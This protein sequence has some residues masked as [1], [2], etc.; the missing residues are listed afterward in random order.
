MTELNNI[1]SSSHHNED[2]ATQIEPRVEI[3]ANIGDKVSLA[4]QQNDFPLLHNLQ[5]ENLTDEPLE[6]LVLEISAD[7]KFLGGR[8]W[9]FDHFNPGE[10]KRVKDLN[11]TLARQYLAS[12]NEAVRASITIKAF[13]G[14][15]KVGSWSQAVKVLAPEDWGGFSHLPDLTAAFCRPNDPAV[16]KV[17]KAAA[18]ALKQAGKGGQISGYQSKDRNQVWKQVSAIYTAICSLRLDY[19]EPPASFEQEG[20]RIRSPRRIIESGL[21]TCLD[22]ALFMGACFEQCGL[23]PLLILTKG[24]AFVGCWLVETDFS[25][26][27]VDDCQS[28]R[29]R[30]QLGEMV[31][32]ETTAVTHQPAPPFKAAVDQANRHLELDDEFVC[33]LDISRARM[34]SITPLMDQAPPPPVEPQDTSASGQRLPVIEDAPELPSIDFEPE[35]QEVSDTPDSRVEM[36]KRKLL[37]LTLRNKLLN[38]KVTK[39]SVPIFC[40]D[41]ARLEDV[42]ADNAT[43]KFVPLPKIMEGDDPRSKELHQA[44]H[45]DDAKGQFARQALQKNEILIDLPRK[46]MEDRLVGLYRLARKEME[47]GGANTLFL[48]MG[49]LNWTQ[50]D[51]SSR[52]LRAPLLLLP[53]YLERTSVRA[54]FKLLLHDD[55]P[56]LNPTLLEMLRK[57]FQLTFP[58]LENELPRD[59]SGLDVPKIWQTIRQRVRDLRG[60]EVTEEVYLGTFSF[61]KYLMWKDLHDRLGQLKQNPVVRHLIETPREPYQSTG[62]FPDC[63]TLDD[64]YPPESI[65]CPL[66]A[67]SS[68]LVA[69][70]AAAKGKDFVVVGPPGT[71]KSQ[72]ITNMIVQCLVEGKT[73]LFV[74]EKMAAL[75]V[76]YRRLRDVGVGAYCLELHSS[77]ARKREV[78]DQLEAAWNSRV[79]YDDQEWADNS[80]RMAQLRIKLN[81]Y[82]RQLHQVFTN[83]LTPYKAL[84]LI[85]PNRD[86]AR[87]NFSWSSANTH[88]RKSMEHLREI[89]SNLGVNAAVVG[90]L[91][92]HPLRGIWKEEWSP[93][94][95]EELR[96]KAESLKSSVAVLQESLKAFLSSVGLDISARSKGLIQAICDLA[97]LL[98]RAAGK[99]YA[100][101]FSTDARSAAQQLEQIAQCGR[102]IETH[103]GELSVEYRPDATSLDLDQLEGQWKAAREAWWIKSYFLRRSVAKGLGP[104]TPSG[105][106]SD[107]ADIGKDLAAL[108]KIKEEEHSIEAKAG[109]GELLGPAWRGLETDWEDVETAVDFANR[110]Q[111]VLTRLADSNLD[112][113]ASVGRKLERLLREASE[114]LAEP[115]QVR[116]KAKGLIRAFDDFRNKLSSATRSACAKGEDALG[117]PDSDKWLTDLTTSLEGWLT[118]LEKLRSWCGWL[119]VRKQG[120]QL[121]LTP[122]VAALENGEIEPGDSEKV[123]EVNYRRW[124]LGLVVDGDEVLKTFQSAEHEQA[125]KKFQD[126]DER[127]LGV[128]SQ[129]AKARISG[130]IPSQQQMGANGRTEW[131]ILNRE[132]TKKRRH[133]PLRKLVDSLPHALTKLTPCLL[134]SPLSVAQYLSPDTALFDVVIFDEASQIPVWDAVGAL[135]RGKQAIV[136]GDPKQLPPTSFFNRSDDE[137]DFEDLEVEDLESILDECQGASLPNHYLR[138]HY[139]SRH[140]S[141]IVFSNQ[142]YYRGELISFPSAITQDKAVRYF[143]VPEGQYEKGKAR[144]NREEAREVV[145]AVLEWLK[146]PN[147]VR[148]GWTLGVVTFNQQQQILIED[149]L[150][151]ERRADPTL[152]R[153]FNPQQIEPVFVKNL[154]NVQ[155]DERDIILFS[156]TY[157]PDAAGRVSMNFGPLNKDGGER[158]LNVAI[159][160]ARRALH[161]Y[162]TLKAEHIDL[163][164]TKSIGVR[165][166]KHFL[167]FAELGPR[168]LAEIADPT[169][170]DYESGFEQEVAEELQRRGWVVHP[171][172]GVSGFRVDLGVVHPDAAGRYLAGVEC[173]GATYHSSAT[174]RDRDRLRESV[175][176]GLGWSIV[177]V[178]STDWWVD[179]QSA[180]EKVDRQ[181]QNLLAADQKHQERTQGD[182]E[183]GRIADLATQTEAQGPDEAVLSEESDEIAEAPLVEPRQPDRSPRYA[184]AQPEVTHDPVSREAE[185]LVYRISSPEDGVQ[186]KRLIKDLFPENFHLTTHN[187]RIKAMIEHVV[188]TEGPVALQ[189][190]IERVARAYGFKRVGN[191]INQRISQLARGIRQRTKEDDQIFLWPSDCSPTSWTGFRVNPEGWQPLRPAE[192]ICTKELA[193]LAAYVQDMDCPLDEQSLLKGMA[194]RLGYKK[195]TQKLE[196]TLRIALS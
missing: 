23:H 126:L 117:N 140:E 35:S 6:G 114:L 44:R 195:L 102:A 169:H 2:R 107:Q 21:G 163:S 176:Q 22:L 37:D 76:V 45:G 145:R 56:C 43:L 116:E 178:W 129:F 141:L 60:W 85:I 134:M 24:H 182:N 62:D 194:E 161:L 3:R 25:T 68:Q 131:G 74:S 127:V 184:S 97:E 160:R 192:L 65:F 124:W 12:L 82:P 98:P 66:S 136:V 95:Q 20:Q 57:D 36:W 59:H 50:A 53:V 164:R 100:F 172:V 29:K 111:A 77:K 115:G 39:K 47:E 46:E 48:A 105:K 41:P 92:R 180:A 67:D 112:T 156:I 190:V 30:Q 33:A 13:L 70:L 153:H 31:L 174:A 32:V 83:G 121:G 103:K 104:Y 179:L 27:I 151:E 130:A 80:R 188:E 189:L 87:L 165:D 17:L 7:P 78:L 71:G 58:S 152:E 143:H 14:E 166:F 34:N 137:D 8:K 144:V 158:R 110:S 42:L 170:G 96:E 193:N 133:M 4:Q 155:G 99:S 183:D 154:E 75:D 171:Q 142:Q 123:F 128:T 86:I 26:T 146:D 5:I 113:R 167:E 109:A 150:D 1:H 69:V 11:V 159:T 187:A 119:R 90:N 196:K 73:V 88:D 175:L 185:Q 132:L 106:P 38:F 191:K 181:L 15:E 118:H 108:R 40:P 125:I 19:T 61:T 94:W 135:A 147:F 122:L 162:G 55:D 157:G 63:K 54:G 186:S 93:G 51:S 148:E 149:M 139:R 173:D 168:A 177:R 120:V 9:K 81:R 91:S 79:T 49:F 10:A 18:Q 16:E 89:A 52:V 138:W 84:S 28:V 72:T 101:V 64:K